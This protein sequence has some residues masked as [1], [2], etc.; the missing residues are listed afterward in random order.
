MHFLKQLK[1]D[2]GAKALEQTWSLR[3]AFS[4]SSQYF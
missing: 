2:A 4:S 3:R 1:A